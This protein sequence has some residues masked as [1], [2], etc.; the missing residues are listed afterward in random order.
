MSTKTK[1]KASQGKKNKP[2]A[3]VV[4]FEIPAD[5]PRRAQKFY[6]TL[7]GWKINAFPEMEDYWH[8][9]TGG[10]DDSPDGGMLPRKHATQPI[11]NYINVSS[12]TK[13]AAKIEKL[14]GKVMK[15]KTAVPEMGYFAVCRDTENNE[16]A[17]WERNEKA[18]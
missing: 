1:S 5:D 18:K 10:S 8:I 4:W 14:G 12:V 13:F 6:S 16:F 2:A 3:S 7:F 17:I 15:P 9:D 11:T